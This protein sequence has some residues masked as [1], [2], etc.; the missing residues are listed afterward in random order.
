M[1]ITIS[2]IIEVEIEVFYFLFSNQL[3]R[4]AFTFNI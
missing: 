3:L 2:T 1:P 4:E